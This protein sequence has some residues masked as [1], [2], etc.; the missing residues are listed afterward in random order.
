M[1]VP[2][3][4]KNNMNGIKSFLTRLA[5][6]MVL[7]TLYILFL[8]LF[9]FNPIFIKIIMILINAL[10]LYE[11]LDKQQPY[12]WGVLLFWAHPYS[13]I[14]D[15]GLIAIACPFSVIFLF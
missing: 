3:A 7:A 5:S 8:S 9:G 14:A 15:Y 12:L 2:F 6:A 13:M 11:I 4:D 1:G 10:L